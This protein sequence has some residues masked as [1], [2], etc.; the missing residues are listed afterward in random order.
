M[1]VLKYLLL[2]LFGLGSG[3]VIAAGVFALISTIGIVPRMAEKTKTSNSIKIYESSIT[4][5]GIAGTLLMYGDINIPISPIIIAVFEFC[6]G[7]FFGELAVSIAEVLNVFPIFMRRNRLT[8]GLGVIIP[9]IAV[10]KGI[11]LLM[12]YLI[13]GFH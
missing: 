7:I 13:S 9:V 11:G 8:V 1:T 3:T 5:G 2:I 4:L 6:V 12:Y 10:G